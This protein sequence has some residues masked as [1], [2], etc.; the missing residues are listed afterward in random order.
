[1]KK[2]IYFILI[3]FLI[4]ININVNAEEINIYSKN[5]LLYN[6]EENK[7]MYKKNIDEKVQ[8]ASLTKI[9]TALVVLEETK[10]LEKEITFDEVDFDYLEKED[11]NIS[12]LDRNKKYTY[13]DF[14]YSLVLESSADCGYALAFDIGKSEA[15]FSRYMNKK[16]KE[17]GMKNTKFNNPVG[18]DDKENNYSTMSD[19][20]LLMK[21]ALENEELAKMMSSM[22]YETSDKTK[23]K[24]TIQN[25]K[26]KFKLKMDYLQ[27]GKTGYNTI[28][29]YALM[30][31]A[32]QK[33]STYI[34]ITTN[35]KYDKDNPKHLND[36]KTLYEYYFKNY[37]YQTVTA[38]NTV[39]INLDT[40]YLKNKIVTIPSN[41]DVKIFLE[42]NYSE[43]LIETKY[44]G[45]E[46]LTPNNKKGDYL[47]TLK[48]YYKDE[49][50][51]EVKIY[52]DRDLTPNLL[53]FIIKNKYIFI[54]GICYSV[55]I[56][57]TIVIVRRIKK[58]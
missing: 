16:A 12:T 57:S 21:A 37:G 56:G 34:L 52:L 7:I 40:K 10:D 48:Y 15:G 32:K 23:I 3:T 22:K 30:S 35:A 4:F 27:G 1:M 19:M 41:E 31:Y 20:L 14:L 24:H 36:A 39:L 17:L 47:G 55:I 6:V 26:D 53:G 8:I 45:I 49:L 43:D 51:K 18:L 11:L 29:G 58:H 50:K 13:K 5:A 25:Y 42:N 46:T 33:D 2:T 38:K 9:M 44:I 28:P 54:A